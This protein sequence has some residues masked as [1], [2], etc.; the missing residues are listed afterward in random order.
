[1]GFTV[2]YSRNMYKWIISGIQIGAPA[3]TGEIELKIMKFPN[4]EIYGASW[5]Q[6]VY[7]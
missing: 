1:M 6:G 7:W 2:V 5:E 3:Q 4:D